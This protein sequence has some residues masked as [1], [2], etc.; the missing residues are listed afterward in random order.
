MKILI[1]FLRKIL[2]FKGWLPYILRFLKIV[3]SRLQKYIY[4]RGHFFVKTKHS[5]GFFLNNWGHSNFQIENEMFWNGI[6]EFDESISIQLWEKFSQSANF[7][8]DIGAN[9][10]IYSLLAQATNPRA[11]VMAFEPI[12]RVRNKLQANI[13]LNK[14][15]IEI[16][17]FAI[18]DKDGTQLICDDLS[19][20]HPYSTTLNK[21]FAEEIFST[22]N[23]YEI[24]TRTLDGLMPSDSVENSQL[25]I[26]VD[27]EQHESYAIKGM[28]ELI[29]NTR[30]I[31]LIEILT[32]EIG[33]EIFS[34]IKNL[35]YDYYRID[36]VKGLTKLATLDVIQSSSSRNFLL[37]HA[38][39]N[40]QSIA[41]Y[42]Y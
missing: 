35:N 36:E 42:I 6:Y 23:T 29:Q 20:E 41:E 11:K 14:F 28:L 16:Y 40:L 25:L 37:A 13:L 1:A 12:D 9:T 39:T 38:E 18:S 5:R 31:I 4:F 27:V 10:G 17:D 19:V 22:V 21:N 3:P 7:I 2:F 30:P 34:Q 15:P 33:D 32:Q 24:E 8:I 26:K